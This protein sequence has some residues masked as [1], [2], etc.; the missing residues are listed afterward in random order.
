MSKS[1][2]K[3]YLTYLNTWIINY[4]KQSRHDGVVVGISGG[5][6]SAIVAN[7]AAMNKNIQVIGV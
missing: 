7:I 5:I 2:L 4:C 1:K 3:N 6:D